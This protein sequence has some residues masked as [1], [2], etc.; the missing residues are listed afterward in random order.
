VPNSVLDLADSLGFYRREGLDVEFVR[1]QHTPQAIV[2]LHNRYGDI[3]NVSVGAL[4]Q[5]VAQDH[6]KLKAVLSADKAMPYLIAART[7]I[8]SVNALEGTKLGIGG[9]GS[10]D[11]STTRA[12]LSALGVDPGKVR[13]VAIGE[14]MVR[15]QA[16]VAGQIDATTISLGVW[17]RIRGQPD[18]KILVTPQDYAQ[19]APGLS[20]VMVADEV[21]L[22]AKRRAIERFISAIVL[23]SRAFA[24]EPRIW[25][26]AMRAARPDVPRAELDELAQLF[27]ASWT[28][29]GG[30]NPE[31]LSA[32]LE[33]H[34]GEDDFKGLRRLTVAE[35]VDTGPLDRV[36]QR[37]GIMPGL[38]DPGR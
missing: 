6:L 1:V 15:A 31:L 8:A 13:M 4:I 38:D 30:L 26:D 27:A 29:N 24:A 18:L 33:R 28:V 10:V 22:A 7:R 14:P 32:S 37:L 23:A 36:L 17:N 12:V 3:A 20:K 34:Y 5:L 9:I 25:V 35:C 16:L 21:T 19:A 11:Y 2:A